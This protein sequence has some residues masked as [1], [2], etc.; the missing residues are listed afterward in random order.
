M[1]MMCIYIYRY[2]E[3]EGDMYPDECR[4]PGSR[5]SLPRRCP[6]SRS[7][8]RASRGWSTRR[9]SH[10]EKNEGGNYSKWGNSE[11][12][13]IV[14]FWESGLFKFTDGWESHRF[15]IPPLTIPPSS[16]PRASATLAVAISV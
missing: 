11:S 12:A 6:C 16:F 13:R 14:K 9:P 7:R 4:N 3:R 8:G 10:L 5:K 15:P 2:R 1:Y